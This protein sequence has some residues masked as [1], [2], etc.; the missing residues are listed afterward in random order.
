MDF[1]DVLLNVLYQIDKVRA[2]GITQTN[3]YS[4]SML[5]L[6]RAYNATCIA[7]IA[8]R[9]NYVKRASVTNCNAVALIDGLLMYILEVRYKY[10][11]NGN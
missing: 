11:K 10:G 9:I 5:A 4:A 7:L 6:S 3:K 8:K 1:V 2:F